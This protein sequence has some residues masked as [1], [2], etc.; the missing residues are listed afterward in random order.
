MSTLQITLAIVDDHPLVIEGLKAVLKEESPLNNILSF[1]LGETF[2]TYFKKTPVDIVLLDI[3][4]P[5][6]NGI[7]ICK[8]VKKLSPET[9]VLG[10]SNQAERSIILQMLQNGANGYLLKNASAEEILECIGKAQD[11]EIA[12]SIEVKKIMSK[13]S[14]Q[15]LRAIPSLTKREKEILKLVADGKTSQ[16]IA[17]ILFLSPLTVDT[18]R[19]NMLHRMQVKN[20]AELIK[21]VT[22][23]KLL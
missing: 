17:E 5:D 12:F 20:I 3:S 6:A 16:Q 2:L 15:D 9:I 22:E 11:G 7:Q 18:H 21:L 13:P 4:L 8:E 14:L 10:L 1:T 23:Y 19:R